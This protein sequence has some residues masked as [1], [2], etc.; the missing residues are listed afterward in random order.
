MHIVQCQKEV[1]LAL[2]SLYFC[3]TLAGIL[4]P[5]GRAKGRGLRG[6]R[7]LD[8][9]QSSRLDNRRRRHRRHRALH[10]HCFRE[11]PLCPG[12]IVPTGR[13]AR[14]FVH[15]VRIPSVYSCNTLCRCTICSPSPSLATT[16]ATSSTPCP[17][18]SGFQVPIFFTNDTI[19][20]IDT[21]FRFG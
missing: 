12:K 9:Q 2:P 18:A 16:S 11:L 6:C 17:S 19:T 14:A 10:P 7:P 15:V 5:A 3:N 8:C 1:R 20:A 21:V 13:H 4:E